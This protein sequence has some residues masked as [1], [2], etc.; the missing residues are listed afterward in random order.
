MAR[1]FLIKSAL[2]GLVVDVPGSCSDAGKRVCMWE[3][4]G[5]DNQL[6]Y[7]DKYTHSIRA[8]CNKMALGVD[9]DGRLIIDDPDS[10]NPL[11]GWCID[12][13]KLQTFVDPERVADIADNNR[14]P[15]AEICVWDYNGGGNQT[16][17]FVPTGS[18][19]FFIKSKLSG[20]ALDVEGGSSDPGTKV[21]QYDQKSWGNRDNQLWRYDW[22]T[23][24]IRSKL[25]DFALDCDGDDIVLNPHS[26]DGGQMWVP[27]D[28]R[29]TNLDNGKDLDVADN[30]K[31]CGGKICCWEFN[32]GDNQLWDFEFTDE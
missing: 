9:D 5:G 23:C 28:E 30:C 8:K 32:G 4:N 19:W 26:G 3:E 17:E 16:W 21:I 24:S 14:D 20:L 13:D 6:W 7:E 11:Q 31:D 22:E 29:I 27:T 10:E 1:Y 12:G 25:N 2:N 15:G 18:P